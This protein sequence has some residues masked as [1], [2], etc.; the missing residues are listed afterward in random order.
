MNRLEGVVAIGSNRPS[1]GVFVPSCVS[2]LR[3]EAGPI[4]QIEVLANPLRVL[5]DFGREG[6]SFLG[7]VTS[8]LE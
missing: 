5:L 3:L 2:D 4:I 6:I 8:L 1:R 7:D